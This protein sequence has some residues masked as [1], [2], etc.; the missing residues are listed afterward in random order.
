MDDF[1]KRIE[2]LKKKVDKSIAER[3][4]KTIAQKIMEDPERA[5]KRLQAQ[6]LKPQRTLRIGDWRLFFIY[7]K[8]CRKENYTQRWNCPNCSDVPDE[9]LVLVDLERRPNAYD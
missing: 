4:E 5:T 9:A 3:I 7:C 2:W 8:E 1:E 6:S